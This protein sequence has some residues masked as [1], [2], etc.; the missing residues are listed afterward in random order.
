M[1]WDT[2][3]Q[4]SVHTSLPFLYPACTE[5]IRSIGKTSAPTNRMIQ[6]LPLVVWPGLHLIL[7]NERA[8]YKQCPEWTGGMYSGWRPHLTINYLRI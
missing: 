7:T 1:A 4:S 8:G 5:C 2:E 3:A 6:D